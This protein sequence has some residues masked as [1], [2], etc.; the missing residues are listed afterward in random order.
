MLEGN[1]AEQMEEEIRKVGGHWTSRTSNN[2]F[3]NKSKFSKSGGSNFLSHFNEKVLQCG[4]EFQA[5]I[6]KKR[7]NPKGLNRR[8]KSAKL[9]LGVTTVDFNLKNPNSRFQGFNSFRHE[10]RKRGL[11]NSAE[12]VLRPKRRVNDYLLWNPE[13]I[14]DDF[15]EKCSSLNDI[16]QEKLGLSLDYGQFM[17]YFEKCQQ[18]E[19]IFI[20]GILN[21]SEGFNKFLETI[22]KSA[23]GGF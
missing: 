8:I 17:R 5:H 11:K 6:P 4:A 9:Q 7:V 2:N 20:D 13:R 15:L 10:V 18:D 16:L 3:Q 23:T 14:T 22:G 1:G 19:G 21:L 12:S